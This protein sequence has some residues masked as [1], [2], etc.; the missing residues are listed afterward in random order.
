MCINIQK[1]PKKFLKK[2]VGYKVYCLEAPN[3]LRGEYN[4][5]KYEIGRRHTATQIPIRLKAGMAT[6][7]SYN[8]GIHVYL[9]Y[10]KQTICE[11][12]RVVLVSFSKPIH[13]GYSKWNVTNQEVV[14]V[15]EIKL[16][17]FTKGASK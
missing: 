9:E 12:E 6:S 13:Y 17:R 3:L 7:H 11:N 8:K 10:P 14:L 15:K 5:L 16:M 4:Y 1:I 2:R